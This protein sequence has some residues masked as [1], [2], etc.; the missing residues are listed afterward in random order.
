MEPH[1]I[2]ALYRERSAIL[3]SIREGIIAIDD[4]KK[5]T[6]INHS[7]KK[8]LGITDEC[9]NQSIADVSWYQFKTMLKYKAAWYGKTVVFA[10]N[11]IVLFG[12]SFGQRPCHIRLIKRADS[13]MAMV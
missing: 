5:I 7:A 13:S 12:G 3:L 8:I 2:A 9:M 1:Q 11:S 10:A 6:M 4:H